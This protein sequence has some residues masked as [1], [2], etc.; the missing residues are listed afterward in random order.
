LIQSGKILEEKI[1]HSF[2]T[3]SRILTALAAMHMHGPETSFQ[4]AVA[5]LTK[6]YG[7]NMQ[8]VLNR[9]SGK[10][11]GLFYEKSPTGLNSAYLK[12]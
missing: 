5:T 2:Q 4:E 6:A 12:G 8:L 9:F 11:P 10:L 3:S 1:S 7:D